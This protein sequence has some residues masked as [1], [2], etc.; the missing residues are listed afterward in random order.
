MSGSFAVAFIFITF[1]ACL[2][3]YILSKCGVFFWFRKVNSALT[4]ADF[5]GRYTAKAYGE[6][7]ELNMV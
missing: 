2:C 5:V 7:V 6:A 4:V 1:A 3:F